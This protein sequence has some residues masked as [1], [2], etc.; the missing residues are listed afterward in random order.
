MTYKDLGKVEY[1]PFAESVDLMKNRQLNATLQSAGLGVA[2]LKDLSTSSEI[3]VVAV[4][5][6][7][8]LRGSFRFFE[9]F[10]WAVDCISTG[11]IDVL[12]I[13]TDTIAADRQL[14]DMA[15]RNK[16]TDLAFSFWLRETE[17]EA[18][19]TDLSNQADDTLLYRT[20][21]L[22]EEI[23]GLNDKMEIQTL[24]KKLPIQDV[25]YLRT[26][27]NEPPFGVD[28][29]ISITN[30]YTMRD[31]EVE[32]PLESNFFFPRAKRNQI[33]RTQA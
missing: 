24:L 13:L 1:L 5:K 19:E 30:P 7:I 10:A 8:E 16:E 32:L 31:F 2:S 25:A 27:V 18:A 28:T 3:S 4:P 14:V 20:A 21:H 6:E 29:K 15:R 17:V 23:E 33:S 11:R 9:E 22:V 26:V 12:P